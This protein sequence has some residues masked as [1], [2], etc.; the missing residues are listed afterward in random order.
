MLVG[1]DAAG[2]ADD[3]FDGAVD[4]RPAGH[5]HA[6]RGDLRLAAGGFIE[7]FEEQVD[8]GYPFRYRRAQHPACPHHRL[9]IGQHHAGAGHCVPQP[10]VPAHRHDLRRIDHP[11]G[12]V[13]PVLHGIGAPGDGLCHRQRIDA[14]AEQVARRHPDS[15][16]IHHG[17]A[18]AATGTA[19]I[20]GSHAYKSHPS[21]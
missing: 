15:L 20:A 19:A 12:Q 14:D 3:G 1:V 2:F 11:D 5:V 9:A 17:A 16:V 18:S 10:L 4:I 8:A 6:Q 7:Q 13:A 21:S